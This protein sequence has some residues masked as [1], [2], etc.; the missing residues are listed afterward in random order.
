[1]E[2]GL[3]LIEGVVVGINHYSFSFDD[4]DNEYLH[5]TLQVFIFFVCIDVKW[6]SEFTG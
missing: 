5:H 1:M 6:I 4:E 2:F 3:G